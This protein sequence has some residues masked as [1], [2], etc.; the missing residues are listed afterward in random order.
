MKNKVKKF[1]VCIIIINILC[2]NLNLIVSNISFSAYEG[3]KGEVGPSPTKQPNDAPQTSIPS[4]TG[5]VKETKKNITYYTGISGNVYEQIHDEKSVITE[6]IPNPKIA[7][8]KVSLSNGRVT[9]TDNNGNYSFNNLTPG[10]YS[11]TFTFGGNENI[12]K[13]TSEEKIKQYLKY[14]GLDYTATAAGKNVEKY[15][16]MEKT[17][18]ISGTG[19]TEIMLAIDCSTSAWETKLDNGQTRL[20]RQKE[21]AK[22]LIESLLDEKNVY[23]GI[24]GFA[25]NGS[26]WRM[27]SETNNKQLLLET[28]DEIKKGGKCDYESLVGGT[29]IKQALE[30][31][32][33]SIICEETNRWIVLLSDGLPTASNEQNQI[34]NNDSDATINE[35]LDSIISE[36]KNTISNIA[37]KGINICSFIVDSS[38][39]FEQ[40][41]VEEIF[42]NNKNV[43]YFHSSDEE[44]TQKIKQDILNHIIINTT[45][46]E[47]I[48]N[49]GED[50]SYYDG[51]E[52]KNRRKKVNSNYK[53]YDYK[54]SEIIENLLNNYT[55]DKLDEARKFLKKTYMTVPVSQS[56]KISSCS[57]D[58]KFYYIDGQKYSKE[59][60]TVSQ[61]VYSGQNLELR[62]RERLNA[63]LI[64]KTTGYRLTLS[65]GNVYNQISTSGVIDKNL[66][67]GEIKEI[68]D[69]RDNTFIESISEN[70]MYGA[71]VDIEYTI[72]LKNV[73][74]VPI[75]DAT[76]IN[77]LTDIDT[78]EESPILTYNENTRMIT[79]GYT[80]KQYG[81]KKVKKDDL[82]EKLSKN[83]LN[84]LKNDYCVT[85]NTEDAKNAGIIRKG[86][87]GPNGERYIKIVLSKVLSTDTTKNCT[88]FINN[89]E[90]LT[91]T[92]DLG[93]RMKQLS[94]N[95][96]NNQNVK[97]TV[98]PGNGIDGLNKTVQGMEVKEKDF[99]QSIRVLIIPPTGK[100]INIICALAVFIECM[101]IV[102]FRN[103]RKRR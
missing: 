8:V 45:E 90:I 94:L 59:K 43:K 78:D 1:L 61:A 81:W 80:N 25:G 93:I 46:S 2:I 71:R 3:L 82:N 76:I 73:S 13:E 44:I 14:N 87:I 56:Y 97:S 62:Q 102:L 15:T 40:Q 33:S 60:Y 18:K 53:T 70:L 22:K 88:D 96:M 34:Y 30:K 50:I 72:I 24:V 20:E 42:A 52:D 86:Q 11:L 26:A 19:A 16:T 92:N 67:K 83:T 48:I 77:Y 103:F 32:Q 47:K 57:Q 36:T 29:N 4:G 17:I 66:K 98:I 7:N 27:V 65:N 64:I 9:Y 63:E 79:N 74:G 21:A 75:K 41:K 101:L 85:I 100:K 51:K 39:K 49:D 28:L 6:S 89:A 91:Y 54:E 12:E 99:S 10:D 23:I 68:K 95:T 58:D 84:K 35:K 37:K 69:I 31:A 38:D 55:P 5:E